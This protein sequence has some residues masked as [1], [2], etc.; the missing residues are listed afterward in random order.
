MIEQQ[1]KD[2]RRILT[3]LVASNRFLLTILLNNHAKPSNTIGIIMR[4]IRSPLHKSQ[5]GAIQHGVMPPKREDNKASLTQCMTSSSYYV[6]N[7]SQI[8]KL[9]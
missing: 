6:Q 8:I 7:T 3:K 1:V 9:N 4:D 5:L 2:D